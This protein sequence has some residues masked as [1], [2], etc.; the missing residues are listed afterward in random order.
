MVRLYKN[1]ATIPA[2]NVLKAI[3]AALAEE[4]KL[5]PVIEN[6]EIFVSVRKPRHRKYETEKLTS[7]K[8]TQE[9]LGSK[10]K[11]GYRFN[12]IS[13]NLMEFSDIPP[14]SLH[15]TMVISKVRTDKYD[16]FE[17][18]NHEYAPECETTCGFD[19]RC[20]AFYAALTAG[21]KKI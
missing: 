6:P 11:E 15:C 3:K 5:K 21:V 17:N 4:E 16:L 1:Y 8:S 9:F 10:A 18:M 7:F 14:G 2:E 20:K 12:G 13:L 19:K